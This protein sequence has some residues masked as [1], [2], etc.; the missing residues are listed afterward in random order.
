MNIVPNEEHDK[1]KGQ[2]IEPPQCFVYPTEAGVGQVEEGV[3]LFHSLGSKTKLP[4]S[5]KTF[6]KLLRYGVVAVATP[7]MAAANALETHPTAFE[8]TVLLHCLNH[9][10]RAGRRISARVGQV[11]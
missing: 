10:L 11:R 6:G 1:Q 2:T 3:H 5:N 4:E 9:V 8:R 7:R